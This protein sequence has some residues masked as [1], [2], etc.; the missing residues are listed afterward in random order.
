MRVLTLSA[1]LLGVLLLA[2]LPCGM[3]GWPPLLR[4]CLAE[5]DTAPPPEDQPAPPP[6]AAAGEDQQGGS[7]AKPDETPPQ[8]E[9]KPADPEG[10]HRR[11]PQ[12]AEEERSY[13]QRKTREDPFLN[14]DLAGQPDA[15]VQPYNV[16]EW[17]TEPLYCDLSRYIVQDKSGQVV[18]YLTVMLEHSTDPLLGESITM[19]QQR[20][21]GE[22]ATVTV[23]MLAGTMQP[24]RKLVTPQAVPPGGGT[25]IIDPADTSIIV[26]YLFDRVE[27][28]HNSGEVTV[29]HEMRQLPL[30]FDLDQLPLLVRALDYKRTDWPFEAG[31]TD[32][33][34]LERIPLQIG[35]PVYADQLS[36]EPATVGCWEFELRLGPETQHWWVQRL[37]PH[38]LIKFSLGELTYTLFQYTP[39]QEEP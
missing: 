26:D 6:E 13:K 37:P 23:S 29:Y 32:P 16:L 17:L 28:T 25:D 10:V 3:A 34:K 21:F 4:P 11:R 15:P 33:A 14:P 18:G 39:V 9:T 8:D 38:K 31:L 22:A 12:T 35:K 20:D 2:G 30:S 19:T 27:I 24:R 5:D 1:V 36:A 7:E